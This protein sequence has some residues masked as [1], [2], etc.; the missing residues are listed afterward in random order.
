MHPGEGFS[1]NTYFLKYS[2]NI[3]YRPA[4]C[5]GRIGQGDPVRNSSGDHPNMQTP[6][7]PAIACSPQRSKNLTRSRNIQR[8]AGYPAAAGGMRMDRNLKWILTLGVAVLLLC[9]AG[10]TQ[11]S[12]EEAEA[13]LCSDMADLDA[14]IQEL[15]SLDE[16]ATVGDVRAAEENVTSAWNSVR[17]SAQTLEEVN[18]EQLEAAYND[19][20]GA[21]Q[22][23]PDDI[24]VSEART[25]LQPYI[26]SVKQAW[27][28][29][30]T[31]A[32]CA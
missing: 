12:P 32:N 6:V 20:D 27:L 10:C 23:L 15:E 25:Q 11:P 18:T 14:A 13:Q 5:A 22:G 3:I 7:G 2:G 16:T 19:L 24:T 8:L 29:V 1:G 30:Y 9:A 4:I 17:S 28:A 21:V 26:D 31:S